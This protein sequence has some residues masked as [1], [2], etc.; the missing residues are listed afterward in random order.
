MSLAS[1]ALGALIALFATLINE[2]AKWRREQVSERRKLRQQT[3]SRYLA[4]LTEAHER[5]R[6]EAGGDRSPEERAAAIERAFREANCYGLRYEIGIVADQDVVDSSERTFQLMRD[7]RDVLAS[8]RG[9]ED[10]Q[11]TALRAEYGES[12]RE[13]QQCIRAELGASRLELTGGS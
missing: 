5:M 2:R 1:T 9:T 3:C 8:G 12:L 13:L 6:A 11:Y 7:I 10:E 4:A